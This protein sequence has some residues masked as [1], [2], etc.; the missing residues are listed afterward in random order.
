MTDR[1]DVLRAVLGAGLLAALP[2]SAHAQAAERASEFIK[3]TGDRLVAVVNGPGSAAEKRQ[4]IGKI[5][6]AAVDVDAVGRFCLGRFW[7]Q[8]SPD[9]QKTYL[10]LFQEVLITNI[11]AKLG[12][13]QGVR[14]TLGRAR[15]QD[16]EQVVSTVVERPNNAPAT[17]EWVVTKPA[18]A[19]RII[20]V[21]A[22][23]TSLR[24]TQRSDY[25]AY[26]QRNNN[27]I[28]ALLV[29]MKT[30]VDSAK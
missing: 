19:P 23:G 6:V 22:E 26:L 21:I 9:Q 18:A 20:D 1:R 12:E 28:D 14:F 10:A 2:A 16:E 17:V 5:I 24:I 3:S 27:S 30:Q 8:T 25:S 13:Y 11:T 15:P 29:A 7:R 4:A